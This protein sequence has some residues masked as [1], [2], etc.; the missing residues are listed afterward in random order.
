LQILENGNQKPPISIA[1]A[2]G[3]KKT[4]EI[5]LKLVLKTQLEYLRRLE[6]YVFPAKNTDWV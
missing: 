5:I 6:G 4:I 1:H 2:V 3:M